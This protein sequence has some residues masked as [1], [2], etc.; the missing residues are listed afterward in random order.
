[1]DFEWSE[2]PATL[3]A[4]PKSDSFKLPSGKFDFL[5]APVQFKSLAETLNDLV[6]A[7][8]GHK[9]SANPLASAFSK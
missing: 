5:P 4:T 6:K 9:R 8:R 7:V 1:M 2:V 3:A